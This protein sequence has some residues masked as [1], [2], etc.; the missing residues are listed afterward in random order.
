MKKVLICGMLLGLLTSVS[1]AQRGRTVGSIG[2][3]ARGASIGP[4]IGP[5]GSNARINPSA[6]NVGHDGIAPNARPVGAVTP[7]VSPNAGKSGTTTSVGPNAGRHV[8][9][10]GVPP[11]SPTIRPNAGIGPER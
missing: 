5:M 6:I 2:P 4:N 1:F 8:P 9:D 11:V 3:A 10:Q 7:T